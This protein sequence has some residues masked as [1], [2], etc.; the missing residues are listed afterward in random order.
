MLTMTVGWQFNEAHDGHAE[1]PGDARE[2]DVMDGVN[3]EVLGVSEAETTVVGKVEPQRAPVEWLEVVSGAQAGADI[4]ISGDTDLT[5]GSEY[6][7]DIVLRDKLASE[8]VRLRL[9][10]RRGSR[11]IQLIEGQASIAGVE[12]SAGVWR[13]LVAG[14]T[15]SFGDVSFMIKSQ[16]VAHNESLDKPVSTKSE[17]AG[18]RSIAMVSMV[19]GAILL[20]GLSL[21]DYWQADASQLPIT[22]PLEQHFE[23]LG[24]NNL[25]V[26]EN[27]QQ[28]T[29]VTGR[30]E[31][32]DE[33]QALQKLVST[34]YSDASLDVQVDVEFIDGIEDIYRNHGAAAEV[35]VLGQGH[36]RVRSEGVDE[37]VLASIESALQADLP[38][39]LKLET[40]NI[41]LE[42][43]PDVQEK[44]AIDPDKEVEAIV[45]GDVPY[46]VTRD[47]ARYFVGSVLP[48]GHTI[49]SIS[50]GTIVTMREGKESILNF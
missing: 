44:S 17:I 7:N 37:K 18:K 3:G 2:A 5:I 29:L 38:A 16:E 4:D 47:Q 24:F 9:Q 31:S 13:K 49:K 14:S 34:E 22:V 36:A 19:V 33:L 40:E 28:N 15:V 1:S 20:G 48:S 26:G 32:R 50:G 21:Q 42:P 6:E 46:V 12:L 23:K 25:I 10:R 45:G 27:T 35:S 11:R 43:E 8:A 41:P 39:L 30:V